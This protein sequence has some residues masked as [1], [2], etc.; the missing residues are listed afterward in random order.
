MGMEFLFSL[1]IV[2]VLVVGGTWFIYDRRRK[3]RAAQVFHPVNYD[4]HR[5]HQGI[6]AKL[7]KLGGTSD[8]DR[9]ARRWLF[10]EGDLIETFDGP[11]HH[12]SR[13][14]GQVVRRKGRRVWIRLDGDSALL[15][16]RT[17]TL[18]MVRKAISFT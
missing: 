11:P 7:K 5:E 16:R 13:R 1:A 12:Q 18:V 15:R 10:E 6:L 14:F 9:P 2:A 4:V 17:S 8:D 3:P